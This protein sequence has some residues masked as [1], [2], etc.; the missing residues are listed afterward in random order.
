LDDT[1]DEIEQMGMSDDEKT[2]RR[3]N[4]KYRKMEEEAKQFGQKY[5]DIVRS[6]NKQ[7]LEIFSQKASTP[8]LGSVGYGQSKPTISMPASDRI[9]QNYINQQ[10]GK[11][12]DRKK[13]KEQ[14]QQMMNDIIQS[15][16]IM[17]GMMNDVGNLLANLDQKRLNRELESNKR[18]QDSYDE[19]FKR[20]LISERQYDE[21]TTK[22]RKENEAKQRE[23]ELR[24]ARRQKA[25]GI[26]QAIV[27][28]G[29]AITQIIAAYAANPIMQAIL[30]GLTS[31]A[32]AAQVA[33]IAS[34]PLPKAERGR[35]IKGKRHAQNGEIVEAED[36]EVILSR[37]TVANNGPL[38][39][40]L[41]R[42]SMYRSGAPIYPIF[43]PSIS[44]Q[45]VM[46][47]GSNA[48][49]TNNSLD[50]NPTND[51][52]RSIANG[53]NGNNSNANGQPVR[54]YVVLSDMI[55][56]KNMY[57]QL[58]RDSGLKQ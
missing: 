24:N 31:A 50:M 54:A 51:L 3:I 18:R 37:N 45:R 46:Y 23:F 34:T 21:L 32:I 29:I 15:V 5:I 35:R 27:N 49:S 2:L 41:L 52:L 57:D 40:E 9:A 14:N 28:G 6:L 10:N 55:K 30:V 8:V 1:K 42:S 44:T 22:I 53:L 16:Q 47:N 4:A 48:T 38:V 11:A 43:N 12:I 39:D 13:Q 26:A 58:S 56:A 33:V 25:I 7:E 19:L 17:Q 20:K 36:G